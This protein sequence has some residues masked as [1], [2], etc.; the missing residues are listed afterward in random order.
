MDK[1]MTFAT[2]KIFGNRDTMHVARKFGRLAV[3]AYNHQIKIHKY[4]LRAYAY[5][6]TVYT[7]TP[8]SLHWPIQGNPLNFLAIYA[9]LL[10]HPSE[11]C[12][13]PL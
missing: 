10:T 12:V 9:V 5:D 13:F 1:H 8:N 3:R 2:Q 4:F 7:V 6:D 11:F